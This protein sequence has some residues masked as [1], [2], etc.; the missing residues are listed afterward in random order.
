MHSLMLS[1]IVGVV[2][3]CS[4]AEAQETWLLSGKPVSKVEAIK[5]L[6]VDRGADVQ[7]CQPQEL[8]DKVTL[9]VK[10]K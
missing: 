7:R 1:V 8:T 9:R 5:A 6:I 10:K 4:W 3:M 2:F